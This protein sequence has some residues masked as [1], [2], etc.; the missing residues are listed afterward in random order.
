M[1]C[2]VKHKW[3]DFPLLEYEY[4]WC[5]MAQE[6]VGVMCVCYLSPRCMSIDWCFLRICCC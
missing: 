1:N 2:S 6:N 3:P 4:S 5:R